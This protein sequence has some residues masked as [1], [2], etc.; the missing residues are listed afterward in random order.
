MVTVSHPRVTSPICGVYWLL[1]APP[2][3]LCIWSDQ[4]FLGSR[5]GELALCSDSHHPQIREEVGMAV[6]LR[7]TCGSRALFASF[8]RAYS[9]PLGDRRGRLPGEH[10]PAAGWV[11]SDPTRREPR[12]RLPDRRSVDEAVSPGDPP[13]ATRAGFR[14]SIVPTPSV[15]G[16]K[17]KTRRAN[18]AEFA[19][20]SGDGQPRASYPLFGG[21]SNGH[22]FFH[23]PPA[24]R[25]ATFRSPSCR[26]SHGGDPVS[27]PPPLLLHVLVSVAAHLAILAWQRHR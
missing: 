21:S 16:Y 19:T 23:K 10:R 18:S 4:V 6:D 24:D 3:S 25:R 1:I 2:G 7:V 15:E 5:P 9:S 14:R 26:D 8:R 13:L 22:H 17:P 27:F 12:S 20:S 11:S